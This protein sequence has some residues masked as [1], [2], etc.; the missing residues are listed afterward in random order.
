MP[1]NYQEI[2]Q[3]VSPAYLAPSKS[4]FSTFLTKPNSLDDGLVDVKEMLSALANRG[5]R[6]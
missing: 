1:K 4:L 3:L 5:A 6:R 2:K